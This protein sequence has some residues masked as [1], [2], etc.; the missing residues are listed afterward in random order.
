MASETSPVP[1][2]TTSHYTTLHHTT[3]HCI[4]LHHT[5]SHYIT[6]HEPHLSLSL[7]ACRRS[8][9]GVHNS[10]Q[11]ALL[12]PPP[13]PR[14]YCHN[15]TLR[16]DTRSNLLLGLPFCSC[17]PAALLL[18]PHHPATATPQRCSCHPTVLLLP[19]HHPAPA[20]TPCCSCHPTTLLLPPHHAATATPPP[21]YFENMRWMASTCITLTRTRAPERA[22]ANHSTRLCVV[23]TVMRCL[24]SRQYR[25]CWVALS[26][27][28]WASTYGQRAGQQAGRQAAGPL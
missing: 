8:A 24:R 22:T 19:P 9:W 26:C 28:S 25:Y 17:H 27:C 14:C 12:L 20:T 23:S 15:H 21:C 11:P 6:L 10:I 4:T 7:P 2:H 16:P 1:T 13:P 5:T 18:P 3:S